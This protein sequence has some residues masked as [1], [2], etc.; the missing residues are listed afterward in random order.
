MNLIETLRNREMSGAPATKSQLELLQHEFHDLVPQWF[1]HLVANSKLTGSSFSIQAGQDRSTLGVELQWMSAEQVVDEA[2]NCYPGII[3]TGLGYLP[4]GICLEGSGDPYFLKF[5]DGQ[6]DTPVVRI[7]H[8]AVRDENLD[9]SRIELVAIDLAE[10]FEW[11]QA[12]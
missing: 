4:F 6:K 8:D 5:G 10:F 12:E 9:E 7:P 3:A 11:S 2:T 1:L